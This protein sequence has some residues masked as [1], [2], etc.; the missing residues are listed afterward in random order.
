MRKLLL[1]V[2]IAGLIVVPILAIALYLRQLEAAVETT[3][4][5]QEETPVT[6]EAA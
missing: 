1:L 2:V 6:A 3:A 4:E 5:V